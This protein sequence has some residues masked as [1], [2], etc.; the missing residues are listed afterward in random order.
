MPP[1][2]GPKAYRVVADGDRWKPLVDIRHNL[3]PERD[4]FV[5]RG[6]DLKALAGHVRAGARLISVVGS[7]GVGKTR[8]L[9]RS[10]EDIVAAVARA[11]D[12]PLGGGDPVRQVGHAIA[13]RGRC[14]VILDNF[15]QVAQHAA[16]TLGAWVDRAGEAVFAVTS[17]GV[18]GLAGETT[19]PLAPL[20]PDEALALFIA[21]AAQAGRAGGAVRQRT[22]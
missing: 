17:R 4:A 13:G 14:L 15:E 16:A 11:L 6:E 1:A 19:L 18:L 7:G 3:P 22:R 2:D 10:A 20:D 12:M 8:L 9:F 21:R 5:G